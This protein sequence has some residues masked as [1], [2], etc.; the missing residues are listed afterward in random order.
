MIIYFVPQHNRLVFL[1]YS[2][3]INK[4]VV[5]N[6]NLLFSMLFPITYLFYQTG[7]DY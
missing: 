3:N 2:T 6:I 4:Y 1:H 7:L 5:V